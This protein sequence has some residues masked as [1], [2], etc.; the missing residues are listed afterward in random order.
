MSL[1]N[2]I[3][4]PKAPQPQPQ[5]QYEDALTKQDIEVLLTLIRQSSFQG[6]SLE[7]LYNLVLKLQNQYVSL[8]K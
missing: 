8:D 4:G 5:S 7:L 6:E 2:K 1:I 3:A